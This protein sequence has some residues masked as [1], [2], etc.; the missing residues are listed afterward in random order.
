MIMDKEEKWE[1]NKTR[2]IRVWYLHGLWAAHDK[3]H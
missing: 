3:K 1:N 2:I